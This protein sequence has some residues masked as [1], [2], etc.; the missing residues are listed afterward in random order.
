MLTEF[1]W[2]NLGKDLL[3]VYHGQEEGNVMISL[4]GSSLTFNLT[5]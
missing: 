4:K 2:R 5:N 1:W 3:L